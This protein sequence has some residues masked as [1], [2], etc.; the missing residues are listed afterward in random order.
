MMVYNATYYYINK[1]ILYNDRYT[2][3]SISKISTNL[4]HPTMV[5]NVIYYYNINKFIPYNDS[6][7]YYPSEQH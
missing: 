6:I 7:K 2:K 1:F 3:L 5:Y 4:Y